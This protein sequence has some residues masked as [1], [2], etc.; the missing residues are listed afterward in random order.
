M[1][2]NIYLPLLNPVKLFKVGR[3][4]TSKYQ[5]KHFDLFQFQERLYD[6]EVEEDFKQIYQTT[7]I[8]SLRFESDFS[9]ISFELI[10]SNG[11]VAITIPALIG[12]PNK[13]FA[14]TWQFKIDASLAGLSTGCY[15]VKVSTGSGTVVL[16]ES[17]WIYISSVPLKNS[18]S[19]EYWSSKDFHDDAIF[20][21]GT[22]F[23]YRMFG[24]IGRLKTGRDVTKYKDERSNPYVTSSRPFRQWPCHFGD[25]WGIPDDVVD[26]LNGIWGC[27]NVWIDGK[28]F[29]A[30][31]EEF[32]HFE[33]ENKTKRGCKLMITEGINR[34]SVAYSQT[35]DTG[36]KLMYAIIV[37]AKVFGDTSQQGSV[38]AVPIITV[39]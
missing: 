34:R 18:I 17:K 14:N 2:S 33:I 37:D 21:D 13:F 19:I 36:K 8:L 25:K 5:T 28:Q 24:Y 35:A 22:K 10:K 27:D 4:V 26:L 15:Y 12:M 6:W 1:D 39:E 31:D 20:K 16:Y 3:A 38:N 11:I 9:P 32:E 29:A 7:D 30:V 23:Q